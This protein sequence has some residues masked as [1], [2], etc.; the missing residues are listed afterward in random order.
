MELQSYDFF[1]P[2]FSP[3]WANLHTYTTSIWGLG[4][5]SNE[6]GADKAFIESGTYEIDIAGQR[7]T[8]KAYLRTPYDPKLERVKA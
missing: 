2:F 3:V 7:V 5:V 6:Q 4:Y 1:F 8:A